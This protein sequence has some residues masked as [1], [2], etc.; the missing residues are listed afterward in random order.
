MDSL[1]SSFVLEGKNNAAYNRI[2][3]YGRNLEIV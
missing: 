3:E 2:L 1:L